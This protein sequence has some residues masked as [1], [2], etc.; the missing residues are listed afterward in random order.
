M[1]PEPVRIHFLVKGSFLCFEV[2]K[3]INVKWIAN[4]ILIMDEQLEPLFWV[5]A[6]KT[7][8]PGEPQN[9]SK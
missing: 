5:Q 2:D 8:H 1:G 4:I 3:S 9:R 6:K 7:R